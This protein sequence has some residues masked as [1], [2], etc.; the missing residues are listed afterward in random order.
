MKLIVGLGNPGNDY[1]RTRHN[2]GFMVVDRLMSKHAG[3][4]IP[5]SRFQGVTI[6]AS[7][8]GEKCVLLKPTTFMNLSGQSVGE[9]VRFF[10]I[11]LA[12]ELLII[13]DELYLSIGSIRLRASGG[14]GGHN[15]LIDIQRA[16]GTDSYPRLRVGVGVGSNGGKPSHMDQADFVLSRFAPDEA[17]HLGPALDRA[18]DASECFVSKGLAATMNAF[19]APEPAA[20]KLAASNLVKPAKTAATSPNQNPVNQNNQ[21]PSTQTNQSSGDRLDPLSGSSVTK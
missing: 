13:V 5:K 20:P 17:A 8:A 7:I 9:A 21:K 14:S 2:A 6:D 18:A 10:K 19:N 11:D 16:L 12:T 4:V 1:S 3:G 15:G